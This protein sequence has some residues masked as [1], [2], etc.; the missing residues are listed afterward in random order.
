MPADNRLYPSFEE[1]YANAVSIENSGCCMARLYRIYS[2]D[3]K[4]KSMYNSLNLNV[5]YNILLTYP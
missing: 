3:F 1:V 5:L 2:V 4:Y